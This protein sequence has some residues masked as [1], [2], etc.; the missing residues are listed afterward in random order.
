MGDVID[1]DRI[2]YGTEA[3]KFAAARELADFINEMPDGYYHLSADD[4][5]LA[6]ERMLGAYRATLKR[7]LDQIRGG[8]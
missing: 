6:A 2:P 7:E 1:L 4:C 5:R 8:R 3:A